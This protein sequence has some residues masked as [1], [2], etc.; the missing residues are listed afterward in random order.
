MRCRFPAFGFDDADGFLNRRRVIVQAKHRGPLAREQHGGRL[1]IAPTGTHRTRPRDDGDLT[2]ET[3]HGGFLLSF[4]AQSIPRLS[5]RV[6]P[7][8]EFQQKSVPL[9]ET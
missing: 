9:L 1:A 3:E 4:T 5:R 6:H 2:F 7:C 8:P